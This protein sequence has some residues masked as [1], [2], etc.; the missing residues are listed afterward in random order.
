M[1]MRI[2]S[3]RRAPS[4]NF[5]I[6]IPIEAIAEFVGA[7][8]VCT[9]DRKAEVTWQAHIEIGDPMVA[10]TIRID[11]DRHSLPSVPISSLAAKPIGLL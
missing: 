7:L 11:V 5:S 8:N 10:E 1:A 2:L 3:T 6:R 9:A 4:A